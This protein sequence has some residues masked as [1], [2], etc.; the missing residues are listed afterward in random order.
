MDTT[1]GAPSA[2]ADYVAIRR[3]QAAYA[4]VVSR[5]AWPELTALFTDDC[6]IVVDR[7]SQEALVLR[8]PGELGRFVG[9]A[10]R[11]FSFFEFAVLNAV[12]DVAAARGRL[13]MCELR[14]EIESGQFTQ[15]F[16]VY[17]DR[18]ER[19]DGAWRFAA[20]RYHSLARTAPEM[21][22]FPFPSELSG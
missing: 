19:H 14:V 2:L 4:D 12:I 3:L 20:R 9:D 13:W 18:Y 5:R 16:G 17:H 10:I 7:R 6:E 8:G 15:A 21:Q 22:V 1:P 11:R